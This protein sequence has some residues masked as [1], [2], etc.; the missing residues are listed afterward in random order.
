LLIYYYRSQ[1]IAKIEELHSVTVPSPRINLANPPQ[2]KSSSTTT[3]DLPHGTPARF[4]KLV[5]P[6][7]CETTGALNPW[8]HPTDKMMANIWNLT[9]DKPN[10]IA[11][12]DF[13]SS[14]FIVVKKLVCSHL[15][16]L[17]AFNN[18]PFPWTT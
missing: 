1:S 6:M 8:E 2:K 16:V 17:W 9:F 11:D 18:F 5:I 14:L 4:S 3:A 12:G 13:T 15:C 10:R 7:A